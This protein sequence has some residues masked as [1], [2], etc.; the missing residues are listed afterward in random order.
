MSY[1]N[2]AKSWVMRR[3]D[4]E[5]QGWTLEPG[6]HWITRVRLI[7]P[8]PNPPNYCFTDVYELGVRVDCGDAFDP[9][10]CPVVLEAAHDLMAR[11]AAEQLLA[12]ATQPPRK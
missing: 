8:S 1:V 9:F 7:T 6:Q 4:V 3:E 2:T 5:V 12:E 11:A 10:T